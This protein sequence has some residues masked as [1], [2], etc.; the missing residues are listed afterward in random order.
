M[1]YEFDAVEAEHVVGGDAPRCTNPDCH[2]SWHG[3]PVAAMENR[4]D[5]YGHICSGATPA[6]PGSHLFDREGRRYR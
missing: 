1:T 3:L 5:D 4:I 6:C 2:R